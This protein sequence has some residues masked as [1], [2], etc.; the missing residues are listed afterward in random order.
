M[1]QPG[2]CIVAEVSFEIS[3]F[4]Y[5]KTGFYQN[6]H[7]PL[8]ELGEEEKTSPPGWNGIV[9]YNIKVWKCVISEDMYNISME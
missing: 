2:E 5:K 3:V 7:I 9:C 8:K 6:G 4:H 1:I